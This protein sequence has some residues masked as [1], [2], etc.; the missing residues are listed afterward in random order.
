MT[1]QW[2]GGT[3]RLILKHINYTQQERYKQSN[4]KSTAFQQHPHQPINP[5]MPTALIFGG[6]GKVARCLTTILVKHSYTVHS[7][8]RNATQSESLASLGAHPIVQSIETATPDSL[9]T[10]I[11]SVNPSVLIW[12]AGA[13]GGDP[14]RTVSVDQ[15]GAIKAF[16]AA[17]LAG[18]T[19]RFILVSALDV[20]DREG[21]PAPEW[22]DDSDRERS[23]KVWGFIG[24]YMKAKLNADR[25]F[26]QGNGR[27]GLE[28]TIVRPGGLTNEKGAGKVSAGKVRLNAVISREDVAEVVWRCIEEDGTKGLAF[29]VAGGETDIAEAIKYVPDNRIDTFA[30]RY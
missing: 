24:P 15:D 2:R 25:E 6:S 9:A 20:R 5:K 30:G 27:R 7:I 8:I 12:A 16:D 28:W 10:T 19:K 18:C 4:N 21:R 17:V 1:R 22:Y 23:E 13:G 26:V 11:R 3:S 29:D 14:G